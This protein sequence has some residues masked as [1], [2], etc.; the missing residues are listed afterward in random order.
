MGRRKGQ[1]GA[2]MLDL[3]TGGAGFIGSHLVD[4]LLGEGRRVRVLDNFVVGRKT[5][6]GQHSDNPALEVIEGDV[7][8]KATVMDA[9]AGADRIFHLAARADVVPSIQ[10]PE[11][12]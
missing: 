10:E 11:A 12:Y 8:D 4:R 3:V 9:C 1:T 2:W 6:L 7:A 5:N